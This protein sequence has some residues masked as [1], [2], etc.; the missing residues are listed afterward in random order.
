M[1]FV[2]A[3]MPS[4]ARTRLQLSNKASA[5]TE[6]IG[7]CTPLVENTAESY[8][9][10]KALPVQEFNAPARASFGVR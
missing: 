3:P 10:I 5:E 1:R 4:E 7:F 6:L 8:L 9:R 2:S